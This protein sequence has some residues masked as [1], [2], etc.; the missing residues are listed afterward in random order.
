M[1]SLKIVVMMMPY[2]GHVNPSLGLM[3]QLIDKG[4]TVI[5]YNIDTFK[6][7][8]E[9]TGAEFR[10]VSRFLKNTEEL[11]V[12]TNELIVADRIL[13]A[14]ER[15]AD[16]YIE[17]VKKENID[18]IIHDGLALW[19]KIVACASHIPAVS[20]VTTCILNPTTLSSF[21]KLLIQQQTRML[22]QPQR[23]FSVIQRYNKL[24]NK[25]GIKMKGL[26]DFV[27]N[28]E[29][30]NIV[31]TSQYYQ[32]KSNKIKNNY[33]FVGPSIISR[34]HTSDVLDLLKTN[35]KIIYISLG[36]IFNEDISFYKTCIETL[37]NS[38]YQ[39]V[40]AVGNSVDISQLEPIPANF[41]I[42]SHVPQLE[43]LKQASLF[44]SHGGM[45]SVNES[46]Y[47]G[48]PMILIPQIFEQVVNSQR[49]EQLK[50]GIVLDKKKITQEQLS[51]TIQQIFNDK[52]FSA[53]AKKIQK[54][55]VEAGGT[56]FAAEKIL[57][58]VDEKI[59]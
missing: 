10:S 24:C 34:P 16:F 36:T 45:N 57:E 7:L 26:F 50:A 35:K 1:K 13:D 51:G 39:V 20:L 41:I 22:S 52:K 23:L 8:I 59:K 31:F 40:L 30:L 15:V 11:K 21:P 54:T 14:T 42:R 33:V 28:E 4:H 18:L 44:I 37:Q 3:K 12:P 29:S 25:Y 19:G 56:Q 38:N 32:P 5:S 47:Y 48:V 53:E 2:H 58:Y 46:L 9:A 43:I 27:V 55:L 17:E 6:P 49:V